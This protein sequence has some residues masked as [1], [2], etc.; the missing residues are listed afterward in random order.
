MNL[1]LEREW[2]KRDST[3]AWRLAAAVVVLLP[4]CLMADEAVG[5]RMQWRFLSIRAAA[6]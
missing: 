3:L 6:I 5:E 4:Y 2:D 1:E